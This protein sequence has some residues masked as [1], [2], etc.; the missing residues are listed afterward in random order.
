MEDGTVAEDAAS[1]DPREGADFD[2]G[3]GADFGKEA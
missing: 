2:P 1:F 3:E